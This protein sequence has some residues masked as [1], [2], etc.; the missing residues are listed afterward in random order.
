MITVF[1]KSTTRPGVSQSTI[2]QNLQQRIEDIR[3]CLFDLVEQHDGERLAAD[4]LSELTALFVTDVAGRRTEEPRNSV[5]L[6]ELTHVEADQ[7]VFF[8]EEELSQS[9]GKL[10]LTNTGRTGEDERTTWTLRILQARASTTDR[11]AQRMDC[12]F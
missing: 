1:L 5:L 7:R 9:L 6:A 4:L 8:A 10:R 11:L 12:L 3:V 2:F